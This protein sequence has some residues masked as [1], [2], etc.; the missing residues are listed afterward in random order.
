MDVHLHDT[1]FVVAHFH[2]VMMGG[3][4]IAFIGGLHHWWPK[5]T[6]KL[7]SEFWAKVGCFFTFVGFN[8]TF[9]SQF[10]LGSKGMPRRYYTYLP[11]YRDLHVVSTVGSWVLAL[12]LFITL[13]CFL[14]SLFKGKTSPKN[15]W[16]GLSLEWETETPPIEHNFEGQPIVTSGP[17]DFPEIDHAPARGH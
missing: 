11:E 5:I 3:T 13:F 12:G 6:G 9:L 1:Y 4:I 7:Y 14:H 17:Y 8:I 2:Y 16:G 15:P 10:V